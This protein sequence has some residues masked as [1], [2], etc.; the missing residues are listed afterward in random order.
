MSSFRASFREYFSKSNQIFY[1]E[2]SILARTALGHGFGE[3]GL[4]PL[5]PVRSLYRRQFYGGKKLGKLEGRGGRP[6]RYPTAKQIKMGLQ[7]YFGT[8]D[9][10]EQMSYEEKR[11]FLSSL[12][13]GTDE[14]GKPYGIYVKKPKGKEFQRTVN[15]RTFGAI[16]DLNQDIKPLGKA[17]AT[18]RI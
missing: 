17:P 14:D 11:G 10:L 2:I 6:D 1:N 13:Q 16:C 12:F 3:G 9:R 15:G 8:L 5:S 4:Y 18:R 7:D